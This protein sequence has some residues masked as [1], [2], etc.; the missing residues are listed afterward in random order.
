LLADPSELNADV[1]NELGL[2][3]RYMG[4]IS[5]DIDD[6]LKS[7]AIFEQLSAESNAETA[8]LTFIRIKFNL[9]AALREIGIRE[10]SLPVLRE[11]VSAISAALEITSKDTS[12]VTWAG[13]EANLAASLFEIAKRE[14]GHASLHQ[15]EDSIANALSVFGTQHSGPTPREARLLAE[16]IRLFG[17]ELVTTDTAQQAN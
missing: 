15:A 5:D 17:E 1:L 7:R 14:D 3:H 13:L 12:P 10:N 9:A 11:S 16:E 6:F 8:P 4:L 2:T